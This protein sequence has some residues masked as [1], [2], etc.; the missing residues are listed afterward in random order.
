MNAAALAR[1]KKS[2]ACAT[3][4][5]AA[6]L[7]VALAPATAALGVVAAVVWRLPLV[8]EVFIMR[9]LLLGAAWISSI[10]GKVTA[11]FGRLALTS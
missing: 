5:P 11:H 7:V 4:W 8:V 2:A 9:P 3:A 10:A 6:A 1:G